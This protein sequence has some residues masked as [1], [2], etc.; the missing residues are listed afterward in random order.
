[1][2]HPLLRPAPRAS[3]HRDAPAPPAWPTFRGTAQFVGSSASGRA[4]VYVD[5]ALGPAGLQNAQDLLADADRVAS[6]NDALFGSVGGAVSVIVYALNGAT[7]GTGGADHAG[8]DYR[9]GGAIEVCA[10]FGDPARVSAL[11]EAELSECSMG[12]TLCGVSTGEAL[13]RWCAAVVGNNA[14]ADFAT[15]PT[16]AADGMADYVSQTDPTD[17]NPASTG[18]GMAF[19][20]WLLSRGHALDAIA[21][22]LVSRGGGGTLAQLYAGLE[23]DAAAN[24]HPTFIAAIE[25]LPNGVTSDDPFGGAAQPAALSPRAVE[26]AGRVF[27]SILADMAAQAPAHQ[28]VARVQALMSGAPGASARPG[29][30]AAHPPASRRLLPPQRRG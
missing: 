11:F 21:P 28:L 24:A 20:S 4:T 3:L 17:Q 2:D 10:A 14:L 19:L 23:G 9:S 27:A 8:C 7:D 15:A 12:G 18:C 6:A 13:S 5:P 30:S 1:M 25:A 22:A 16:W 26:L 29:T